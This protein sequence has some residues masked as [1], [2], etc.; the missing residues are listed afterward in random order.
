M[1][2]AMNRFK[3]IKGKELEFENVWRNRDT[4]L[5]NVRGFKKFNLV[6]GEKKTNT[7]YM[8]LIAFGIQ[9]RIF[10]IGQSL[11]SLGLLI[12]MQANINTYISVLL[13]LKVLKKFYKFLI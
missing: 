12:R 6:K 5:A 4:H 3:I 11:K 7:H 8:L 9:R 10:G 1:F 13:I 2:V